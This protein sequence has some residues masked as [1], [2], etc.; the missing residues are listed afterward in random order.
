MAPP[1][2]LSL[3]RRS[4]WST[5]DE[6]CDIGWRAHQFLRCELVVFLGFY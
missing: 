5:N 6:D 4:Q 2:S 1:P 3:S